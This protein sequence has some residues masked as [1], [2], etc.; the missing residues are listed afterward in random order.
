M[1]TIVSARFSTEDAGPSS[2][3][4][5][6]LD[7]GETCFRFANDDVDGGGMLAYLAGGGTIDLY[8]PPAPTAE[9]YAAAIQAHVD[10]TAKAKG[11]A[12][13]VALAGYST[14]TIPTWASEAATFIAW[15]D[16]VWLHAYTELAKVQAGQRTAPTV[17]V[18]LTELPA[19]QWPS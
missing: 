16:Q 12:D 13:G 9:T 1:A 5:A 11:Y 18:F 6:T 10:A 14:S 19:K 2:Q 17:E 7:N 8:V 4:I 3:V 15:R